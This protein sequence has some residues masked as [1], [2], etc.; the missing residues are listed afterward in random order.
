MEVMDHP[1]A[2]LE[3]AVERFIEAGDRS[4]LSTISSMYDPDF[5]N[6]RVADTGAVTHLTRAQILSILERGGVRAPTQST[7]IH[8]VDILGNMGLVLLTRVKDLGGGWEPM[9]YSLIWRRQG[10]EWLLLRE[11]V[12]QRSMPRH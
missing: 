3:R 4:D 1:T 10:N 6:V 11:F 2:D 12:H 9:F 8:H 7:S 5:T